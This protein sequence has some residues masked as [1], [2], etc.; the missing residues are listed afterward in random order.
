MWSVLVFIL[1]KGHF[2]STSRHNPSKYSYHSVCHFTA[3]ATG[4]R[5]WPELRGPRPETHLGL[6]PEVGTRYRSLGSD[7]GDST[8]PSP[9]HCIMIFFYN[10]IIVCMV[11]ASTFYFSSSIKCCVNLGIFFTGELHFHKGRTLFQSILFL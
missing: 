5:H 8:T 2:L 9:R 6:R 7:I 4:P 1:T 11:C 3:T 10:S